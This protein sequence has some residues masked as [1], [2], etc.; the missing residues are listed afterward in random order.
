[1]TP[2]YWPDAKAHLSKKDR[3]L[4]GLIK[5]YPDARLKTRGD[6]FQTLA[7]SIVGQQISVKAAQSVW[8][9]FAAAA[10]KVEPA[11]VS[12]LPVE[13]LR[14]CGLSGMKAGYIRDLAQRFDAGLLRP[15]RWKRMEDEA[16]IEDLVQVKGIGRWSA[17]MF[18]MFH[19]MRPNVLPVGDLGLQRAM[20]RH[21]NKGKPLTKDQ[22][23]RIGEPWQPWSSVATW[24]LW[25]SLD[26]VTVVY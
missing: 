21:Y 11:I 1:M 16:V 8:N 19:M 22:M 10:G 3:V 25:R 20:E 24:Y 14:A 12:T 9:R 6:A 5:T 13:R 7:R 15:R 18:L 4:R 2:D 23:R 17:E 26:P